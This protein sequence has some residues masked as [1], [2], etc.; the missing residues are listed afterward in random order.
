MLQEAEATQLES[1]LPPETTPHVWKIANGQLDLTGLH[2]GQLRVMRSQRRTILALAGT[3]SG[4][5]VTG[6][7]WLLTEIMKRGEG[8]Y[9]V[10]GPTFPLLKNKAIPELRA[11]FERGLKL[12]KM[13]WKD[14]RFYFSPEGCKKLLGYYTGT[15]IEIIF[16]YAENPDSLEAMTLKGLWCDEAGQKAFKLDSYWALQRRCARYGARQL[17]TT[18]PYD[19][20][21]LKTKLYDLY[22]AGDPD[23]DVIQFESKDNPFFPMDEWHRMKRIMPK[24]KFDLMYRAIFTS[25]AGSIYDVF[26]KS[27]H[28]VP[29]FYVPAS[30]PRIYGVDFGNVNTAQVAIAIDPETLDEDENPN[31]PT[32]Y[33]YLTYK[34]GNKSE[35]EHV[36]AILAREPAKNLD[37][38]PPHAVGGARS[39]DEWRAAFGDAGL[40]ISRPTIAG[41]EEGISKVYAAFAEGRLFIFNDLELLIEEAATYSRELD[42]NDEPT[43]KIADKNKFHRLDALRYAI[44]EVATN[45]ALF[46]SLSPISTWDSE[47]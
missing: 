40:P 25:P 26:D 21:W 34:T 27:V 24:W 12:G 11:L 6:P 28:T 14:A 3:Q 5:T 32:M 39:E 13:N 35:V 31:G 42:K 8:S 23:I 19:L 47:E 9:A 18:T 29:R 44:S 4:K 17:Y 2:R 37:P 10:V 7:I 46:T 41:V 22:K 36:N 1:E 33:V 16:G 45:T 20:G 38:W 15:G 43:D 30:W